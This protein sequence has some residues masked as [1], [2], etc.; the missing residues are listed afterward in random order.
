MLLLGAGG[1]ARG[2][3]LPFLRQEPSELVLVNRTLSKA[4]ALGEEF[5]GF[6]PLVVSGYPGLADLAGG[7]DLV[8][9]ATSASLR[10]EMP[11]V[12]PASSAAPNSPTNS[13]TARGSRRS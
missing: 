1:A 3:L 9:N 2:A 7:Y 8:V 5:A 13:L 4:V 10:G 6:G 11:P 12:P